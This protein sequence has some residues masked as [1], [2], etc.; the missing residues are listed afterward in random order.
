MIGQNARLVVQLLGGVAHDVLDELRVIVGVF[1]DVLLVVA[2]QA[3]P[4]LAGGRRFGDA[5]LLLKRHVAVEL[6]GDRD[7]RALVVRAVVADLAAARAQ[8]RHRRG[9]LL[10]DAR[11]L[12]AALGRKAHLVVHEAL[13]ARDGARLGDEEGAGNFDVALFSFQKRE[14]FFERFTHHVA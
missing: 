11:G 10:H 13:E 2:L 6:D 5:D 9:D 4:E 12:L 8:A 1:G 3:A 7:A 14:H